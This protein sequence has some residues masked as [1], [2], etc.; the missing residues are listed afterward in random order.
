M[1]IVNALGIIFKIVTQST[2]QTKKTLSKK[3]QT[4]NNTKSSF[5]WTKRNSCYK[6]SKIA[7]ILKYIWNNGIDNWGMIWTLPTSHLCIFY[8]T[9]NIYTNRRYSCITTHCVVRSNLICTRKARDLKATDSWPRL[10][11][12]AYRFFRESRSWLN[13]VYSSL[14]WEW[15]DQLHLLSWVGF[16]IKWNVF[17]EPLE[18]WW[19]THGTCV[20]TGCL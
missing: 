4:D 11:S 15:P 8:F 20:T 5:A 10:G 6:W 16:E 17:T 9:Q 7:H 1:T 2:N 18:Q 19:W 3:K 12:I 13:S 14:K